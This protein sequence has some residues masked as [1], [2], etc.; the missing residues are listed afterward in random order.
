QHQQHGVARTGERPQPAPVGVAAY[1][2]PPSAAIDPSSQ[3]ARPSHCACTPGIAA[4]PAPPAPWQAGQPAGRG[5]ETSHGEDGRP[6]PARGSAGAGWA[7]P[8]QPEAV[9]LLGPLTAGDPG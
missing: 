2:V 7:E 3:R 1:K 4:P 8:G 6:R 5:E 9:D